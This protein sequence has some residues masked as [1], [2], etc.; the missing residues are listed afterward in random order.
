MKWSTHNQSL[1]RRNEILIRFEVFNNWDTELKE[2]NKDKV[3]LGGKVRSSS[4]YS[5]ISREDK[6]DRHKNRI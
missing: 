4:N 3:E 6:Q 5:T 2:M 1:V